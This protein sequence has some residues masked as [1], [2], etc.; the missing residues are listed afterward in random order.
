[1]TYKEIVKGKEAAIERA[2][3]LLLQNYPPKGDYRLAST[4]TEAEDSFCYTLSL[5]PSHVEEEITEDERLRTYP[6]ALVQD[7]SES[8]NSYR[9]YVYTYDRLP[10]YVKQIAMLPYTPITRLAM[11]LTD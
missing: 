5:L 7:I 1:M 2:K 9:V 3:E 6:S 10:F 8:S 11:L 4:T